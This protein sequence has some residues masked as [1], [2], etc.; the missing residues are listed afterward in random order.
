MKTR[1]SYFG[2]AA[3]AVGLA[4][5]LFASPASQPVRPEPSPGQADGWGGLA[6]LSDAEVGALREVA[7]MLRELS[8]DGRETPQ[9]RRVAIDALIRVHEALND[10][11]ASEASWYSKRLGRDP[12]VDALAN[13]AQSHAKAGNYHLGGVR[14]L[15]ATLTEGAGRNDFAT[16]GFQQFDMKAKTFARKITIPRMPKPVLLTA[17]KLD[18]SKTLKPLVP[19]PPPK[20]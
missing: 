2:I 17:R 4:A 19:P 9:A 1:L 6:Q 16:R 20:K 15:W 3:A 13:L 5:C 10:W 14:A 18:L 7:A 8:A 11:N 12:N